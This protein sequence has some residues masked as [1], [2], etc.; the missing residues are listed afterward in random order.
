MTDQA[1]SSKKKPNGKT[2]PETLRDYLRQI[3]AA[4]AKKYPYVVVTTGRYWSIP[5]T[6]VSARRMISVRDC[7]DRI[8]EIATGKDAER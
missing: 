8:I 3:P 1:K 4:T 6:L 2:R 7:G 5:M